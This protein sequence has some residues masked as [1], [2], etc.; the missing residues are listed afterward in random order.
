MLILIYT[1]GDWATQTDAL[2]VS[3]FALCGVAA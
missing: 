2:L 1:L 3:I